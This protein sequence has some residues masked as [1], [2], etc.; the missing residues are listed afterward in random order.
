LHASFKRNDLISKLGKGAMEM[1]ENYQDKG[2]NGT[3]GK[4]SL[5]EKLFGG[6]FGEALIGKGKEL[7]A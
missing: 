7:L 3:E 1:L 4:N 6:L 5:K 2:R